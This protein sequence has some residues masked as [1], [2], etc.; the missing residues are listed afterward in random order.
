M[1]DRFLLPYYFFWPIALVSFAFV[2][3]LPTSTKVNIYNQIQINETYNMINIKFKNEN[4]TEECQKILDDIN[5]DNKKELKLIESFNLTIKITV[6][7]LFGFA[8]IK[9]GVVFYFNHVFLCY[10]EDYGGIV[11]IGSIFFHL[12][13]LKK[14][15]SL[16]KVFGY[17]L[18]LLLYV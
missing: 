17:Y 15:K 2:F 5:S 9:G 16:G 4:K 8:V 3:F 12:T 6:F 1:L 13:L 7:V 18:Y 14:M 11:K 10:Y